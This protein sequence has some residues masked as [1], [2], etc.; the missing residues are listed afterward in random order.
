MGAEKPQQ[1]GTVGEINSPSPCPTTLNGLKPPGSPPRSERKRGHHP[2]PPSDDDTPADTPAYIPKKTQSFLP[3]NKAPT[4]NP[5]QSLQ[6]NRRVREK[7]SRVQHSRQSNR[8]QFSPSHGGGR[9]GLEMQ[10]RAD[11][12]SP[13]TDNTNLLTGHTWRQCPTGPTHGGAGTR[14]RHRTQAPSWLG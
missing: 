2:P 1:P 12:A 7:T 13:Q 14:V 10:L 5:R 4:S 8:L 11:I 3:E 9:G 6:A